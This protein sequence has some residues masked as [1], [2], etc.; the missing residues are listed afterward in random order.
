MTSRR[1]FNSN[2]MATYASSPY[3]L[4]I[5]RFHQKENKISQTPISSK[6]QNNHY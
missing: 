3:R 2:Y 6:I 4:L 5:N 1:I